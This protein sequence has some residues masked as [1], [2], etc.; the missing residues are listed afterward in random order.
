[1]YRMKKMILF[2]FGCIALILTGYVFSYWSGKVEHTNKL[3]ADRMQA[4]IIEEF[5]Q[6]AQP[7]GNVK[8]VVSFQNNSTNAAFLRVCYAETWQKTEEGETFLLNN[9]VNGTSV[10]RK[11]WLNGFAGNSGEWWDGEDGWFYYKKILK[12]GAKTENV[13]DKVVFPAYTGV[14]EVY[15]ESSY[16]LYFRMELLQASD[17]P[18]TLNSDEVNKNAS[19]TVFGKNAQIGADGSSVIWNQRE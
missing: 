1:M 3:Q 18:Y 19:E 16:Q 17:S 2:A 4:V 6:G 9:H 15:A 7:T 5:E 8:K 10:A 14:Y 12:P 11:N 13:L